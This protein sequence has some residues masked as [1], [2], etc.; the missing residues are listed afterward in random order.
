M[1][2]ASG[3]WLRC[4]MMRSV[5]F[6]ALVSSEKKPTRYVRLML[7]ASCTASSV[8]PELGYPPS[9]IRSPGSA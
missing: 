2:F 6:R 5:S 8:L 4:D 9:R 3:T 1:I 7:S